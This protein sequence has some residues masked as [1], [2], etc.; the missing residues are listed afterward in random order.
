MTIEDLR[1]QPLY[2]PLNHPLWNLNLA[3][4]AAH[5]AYVEAISDLPELDLLR[6]YGGTLKR[7][8]RDHDHISL[9]PN[10]TPEMEREC[11][12]RSQA[13]HFNDEYENR[14]KIPLYDPL[15]H[16]TWNLRMALDT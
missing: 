6:L 3:F 9:P 4:I 5:D 13:W 1:K 12:L 10:A 11:V 14:R 2:E 16:P 8:D 15:T 7:V